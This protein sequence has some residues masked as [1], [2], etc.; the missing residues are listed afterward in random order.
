LIRDYDL[1]INPT[2]RE[3]FGMAAIEVLAAGV[4][5][6]STRTGIIEQVLETPEFLVR[7][8]QAEELAGALARLRQHWGK[9][10]TGLARAQQNIRSKFLIDRTVEKLTAE[11][12]RLRLAPG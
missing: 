10:E 5:L 12:E 9:L 2:W 8:R 4:P 3:S 1:A 6:L 11:Y 7:P